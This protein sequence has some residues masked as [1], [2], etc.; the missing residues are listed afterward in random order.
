MQ[1]TN[2]V[3]PEA[4]S[5]ERAAHHGSMSDLYVLG[6]VLVVADKKTPADWALKGVKLLTVEEQERLSYKTSRLT[7][8]NSYA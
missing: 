1:T 3:E 8:W 5:L 4:A 6:Q 2:D 7:P